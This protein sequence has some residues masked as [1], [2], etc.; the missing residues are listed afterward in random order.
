MSNLVRVPVIGFVTILL[1]TMIASTFSANLLAA[2]SSGRAGRADANDE[3]WLQNEVR[4]QLV[5]LPFYSL[6]DNF[7]YSLDGKNVTLSGQVTKP[8]LKS[9]AGKAVKAI[10]GIGTV[11]NQIE[12][13]P[14]SPNDDRIRQA[15]YRAIYSFPSLQM[16]ALRAVPPIHII[17]KNGNITLTG[18]VAR[19]SDKDAAGIRAKTVSGAFSVTN[20]LRV[21]NASA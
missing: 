9:D 21:E 15:T 12:V 8:V 3:A 1:L 19:Q 13:L 16:Y 10:P 4:E 20:N 14:L 18:V 17:V 5:T 2:G 7:E 11:D 6:F